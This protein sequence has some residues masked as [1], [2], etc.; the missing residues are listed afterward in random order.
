MDGMISGALEILVEGPTGLQGME[1]D[2]GPLSP[3][4]TL[5]SPDSFIV[6]WVDVT[7]MTDDHFCLYVSLT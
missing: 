2:S 7:H 1:G 6:R 3:A 5:R 4:E